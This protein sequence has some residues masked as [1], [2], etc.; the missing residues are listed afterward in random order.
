MG[1]IEIY[2]SESVASRRPQPAR[3]SPEPSWV[4]GAKIGSWVLNAALALRAAARFRPVQYLAAVIFIAAS[5]GTIVAVSVILAVFFST[6]SENE[7]PPLFLM[8]FGPAAAWLVAS[9][10]I[11]ILHALFNRSRT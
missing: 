3:D 2:Y 10:I 9:P 5:A 8:L 4:G 11:G 6:V 1:E 7:Q